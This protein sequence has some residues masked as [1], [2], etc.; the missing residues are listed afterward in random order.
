ML[1][2][3]HERNGALEIA[4][5]R[6]RADGSG[7]SDDQDEVEQAR[8]GN[9]V[10]RV[11]VVGLSEREI[12]VE[13]PT[14]MG[15]TVRLSDDIN[16]IAVLSMGQNRWMFKTRTLG[17]DEVELNSKRR[18]SALRLQ[19]PDGVERC[20]RR[21]FY[22]VSTTGLVLPEVECRPLLDP[23]TAKPA[24]EAVRARIDVM[25]NGDVAGFVGDPE[26]PT[27]QPEVGPPFPATLVNIGGGGAGLLIEQR[28]SAGVEHHRMFWV[29]IHLTPDIP[30]P[31]SVVARLAHTH[32]DSEQRV[33]AGMAFEFDH[34]P[35]YRKF[36]VDLLCRYVNS[37]QREQLKRRADAG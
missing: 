28:Y 7:G 33:Y 23:T 25:R 22:R 29:T 13:E 3:I 4:V 32:I 18:I 30:A 37:V 15:H 6:A 20:Q 14:A 24:E 2:Q 5:P 36:L 1:R 31:V 16:L 10:W 21:S 11:R 27:I 35:S 19:M 34:N 26:E 8:S 9:L 17:R 12:L